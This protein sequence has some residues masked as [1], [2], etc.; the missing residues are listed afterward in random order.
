MFYLFLGLIFIVVLFNVLYII[1]KFK[2]LSFI[3]NLKEK[4]K[5]IYYILIIVF[6]SILVLF[7]AIDLINT[8]VVYFHF[9]IFSILIDLLFKLFKK[10]TNNL[11]FII[12]IIVTLSY[13]GYGLYSAYNVRETIYNLKTNK[14][15]ELKVAQISDS[16]I[17][18]TFNGY[19][20]KK[21]IEEIANKKPD[22][23][24]IT[25]D[26][27]DDST[28]KKDMIKACE[29]FKDLN[30]KYG[31]YFI[32]G[33]HDKGYFDH[34]FTENDLRE[35]LVKNDV[36]I[37]EDQYINIGDNAILVGRQDRKEKTRKNAFELL[38][39]LDDNKYII[40]L[41]HEPNDYEILSKTKAD[42]VLSG[43]THGGQMIPLG[44]VG[45][46]LGSNDMVYG[47]EKRNNT[48]FIVSSGISSW[49]LKFKTGTISEYVI[50]NISN[51]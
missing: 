21:Y 17:G 6:F 31:V 27:V 11:A 15:I 19:E 39:Y 9:L 34:D 10:S 30:L 16:H 1:S 38:D 40:V 49:S 35:N 29:A 22:L 23:L 46:V 50:I 41:D 7:L 25:G 20:F 42:L 33:N 2:E 43:H 13:M 28:T 48:D 12:S 8:F 47:H 5:K 24:V 26:F 37:L 32:F 44:Q 18:T 51:N 45:L 3:K 4:N 14:D 36:K